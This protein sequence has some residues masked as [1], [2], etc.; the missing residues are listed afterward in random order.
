[1]DFEQEVRELLSAN[2][3]ETEGHKYTLPSIDTYPY[4]WLWDSC[5]HAIVLSKIEPEMAKEELRSLISKQFKDGMIPHIIYWQPSELHRFK[6]GTDGTSALTQ[7]PVIATAVWRIYENTSDRGFLR[8][9]FTPLM[10]FFRY[11]L[12]ERDR[13]GHHLISIINPDESGEDNSPRFDSVLNIKDP[14][15]SLDNHLKKRMLLIDDFRTC[16]FDTVNC[17]EKFFWVKDVPFNAI[18]VQNLKIMAEICS[19]LEEKESQDFCLKQLDLIKEAMRERMYEDG[20]FWSTEGVDYKKIKIDTWAH[21]APLYAEIYSKE[22]AYGVV[23]KYLKNKESFWAPHGIRTTAK[24][25][26]S[27]NPTG[28]WRGPI[29]MAVHWFI[30][31]GL[32]NYGFHEE[33]EEIKEKT[34]E[35]LRKEGFREY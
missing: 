29:W 19:I 27:Y 14:Q 8:E 20:V 1:M 25:E 3:R 7:P 13:R 33:A 32:K 9:M 12:E 2:R 26:I 11:L 10:K 5:F 21:F 24:T 23:K 22:E 6:W 16:K 31:K 35:L 17:M 28:F 18:M 15:I 4:Q 34:A 30:Y